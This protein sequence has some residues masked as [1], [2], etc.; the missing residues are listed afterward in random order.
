MTQHFKT[1]AA[2]AALAALLATG[3]YLPVNAATPTTTNATDTKSTLAQPTPADLAAQAEI[4][5]QQKTTA[6]APLHIGKS[7][8]DVPIATVKDDNGKDRVLRLNVFMPANTKGPVPALLFVHGGGWVVGSYE[9]DEIPT[10]TNVKTAA[11][12]ESADKLIQTMN[13]DY[14]ATY[15][16]F[17]G[18]VNHGIAFVSV[19]YRLNYE[20]TMPNQLYDVKAAVRFIRAHAKEYG[21]DLNRIAIAGSSAGAHLAA[22]V[23]T[24]N[25]DPKA[26]GTIGG[27][28]DQSSAVMACV[29]YYGPT[30]LLTMAPEMSPSL[31]TPADAA[32]T[33]DA[34]SAEE[35]ILVGFDKP[36]QGVGVLRALKAKHDTTSPDW[37]YVEIADFG[38]PINHVTPQTPP[39]FIAH[40]GHD[41]L[42]PIEQSIRLRDKLIAN[43][44]PNVF[45][46]NSEAPHG[47]QGDTTNV[48]M[49]DWL[50]RILK[51]EPTK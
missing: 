30:D 19:D 20:T 12:K 33:H 5:A 16:V 3:S 14:R 27:N 44:V 47:F 21:I 39:F 38:S 2:S 4:V 25:N 7:Y 51:A 28:L 40:G 37:K 32:K 18:V 41:R 13:Q 15:H 24:T 9:G 50:V 42:V 23:A 6:N 45:I 1:L 29:D 22:L 49:M 11:G 46:S 26:E 10:T 48:A 34:P 17:K 43:G 36:G 35:S 8:R 31:Q